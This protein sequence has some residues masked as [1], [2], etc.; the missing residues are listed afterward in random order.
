MV[1]D[2]REACNMHS[3]WTEYLYLKETPKGLL[4]CEG[5][6]EYLGAIDDYLQCNDEGEYEELPSEIDGKLIRGIEDESIVTE[7]FVVDETAPSLL[8][9]TSESLDKKSLVLWLK[10]NDWNDSVIDTI[11]EEFKVLYSNVSDK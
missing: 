3:N 2:E 11:A 6:F 4:V 5:G 10:K 1:I 8:L 9:T 7:D